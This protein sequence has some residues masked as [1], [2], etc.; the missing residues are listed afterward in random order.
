MRVF[1]EFGMVFVCNVED[2]LERVGIIGEGLDKEIV[3]FI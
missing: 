3:I 2:G 1:V